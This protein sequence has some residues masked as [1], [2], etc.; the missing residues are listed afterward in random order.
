MVRYGDSVL[1]KTSPRTQDSANFGPFVSSFDAS[2]ELMDR[3]LEAE[4]V[5]HNPWDATMDYI[6]S[7]RDG[8]HSRRKLERTDGERSLQTNSLVLTVR[9]CQFIVSLC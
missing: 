2:L 8:T 5:T 7:Y 4:G 1:Q 6:Q 3:R 9:R